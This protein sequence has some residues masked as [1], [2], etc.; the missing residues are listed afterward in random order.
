MLGRDMGRDKAMLLKIV[1]FFIISRIWSVYL[2]AWVTEIFIPPKLMRRKCLRRRSGT[3]VSTV[4]G[5]R[6][7]H[8][9]PMHSRC[10]SSKWTSWA[11]PSI[12][13]CMN[14]GE[15]LFQ[16]ENYNQNARWWA[17]K[18]THRT[19]RMFFNDVIAFSTD[20]TIASSAGPGFSVTEFMFLYT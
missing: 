11:R 4:I 10:K 8:G 13:D 7:G 16:L 20:V 2:F 14:I 12:M 15:Q 19:A 1:P 9:D 6:T 17:R 18:K 3:G 5:C